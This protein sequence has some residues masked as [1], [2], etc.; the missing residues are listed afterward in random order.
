MNYNY[1]NLAWGYNLSTPST[2]H[3]KFPSSLV[4]TLVGLGTL[5]GGVNQTLPRSLEPLVITLL[6]PGLLYVSSY[7][8]V[9]EYQAAPVV[10]KASPKMS[11]S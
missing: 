8:W 2:K 1:C 6:R 5:S 9:V 11:I 7:S 3:S 4:V 10:E